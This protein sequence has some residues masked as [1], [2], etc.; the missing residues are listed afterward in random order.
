[1]GIDKFNAEGYYDPTTYTALTNIHRDEMAAEKKA[2]YCPLVYICSPYAGDIAKNVKNARKYSRFAFE[3]NTI[4]LAAHLLFPQFMDDENP[5]ERDLWMMQIRQSVKLQCILTMCCLVNARNCGCSVM[6]F[7]R[8]W[9][10]RLVL[11]RN[12][13]RKS[14]TFRKIVRRSIR[15]RDLN[16][17]YEGGQ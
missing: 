15:M 4:P 6:L 7:L 3:Q 5:A 17:A 11:Q 2:A 12:A 16:I 14:D 8:V 1:M 9:H 10:M 13:G